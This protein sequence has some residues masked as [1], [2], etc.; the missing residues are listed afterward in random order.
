MEIKEKAKNELE[1]IIY[2]LQVIM[3]ENRSIGGDLEIEM[4]LRDDHLG[5]LFYAALKN[6][7]TEFEQLEFL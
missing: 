7:L 2:R 5:P 6:L 1:H 3:A 4:F